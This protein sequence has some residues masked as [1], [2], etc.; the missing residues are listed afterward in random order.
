LTPPNRR[1][2]GVLVGIALLLPTL[3]AASAAGSPIDDKKAEAARL[4]AQLDRQGE[5]ISVL[6]EQYNQATLQLQQTQAST[7]R[8]QADLRAADERFGIVRARMSQA[9]VDAYM[10]GGNTRMIEQ[11]VRTNGKDLPIRQ[12]YV[13][14]AAADQ[15]AALDDLRAARQDLDA[16]RS[17]LE[18]NQRDAKTASDKLAGDRAA[19]ERAVASQQALLGQVKGD[20]ATLIAQQQ[21]TQAA[22]A[23]ARAASDL[24]ARQAASDRPTRGP[25]GKATSAPPKVP[26]GPPPPVGKGAGAAIGA[27]RSQIGK[28]YQWGAAGPDSYDCSGL[29]MWSWAHGGVSLS[30]STYAQWDQTTHVAISAMQPGDILFF[31]SDLHHNALYS[32]GGMMIEAPHTGA[33]VR[34]V[35]VRTSD[36]YGVGRVSG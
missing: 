13:Q 26:S 18:R 20:L 28:P 3:G 36:L 35:P 33:Y 19:V 1:R 12:Q 5:R 23:R 29:V 31:G 25:A 17:Q 2:L 14:T 34:E 6:D 32:G 30:H 7:A 9:A 10:H 22:A 27:A 11:L 4:Q 24:A 21:A 8:A 16:R 15:R